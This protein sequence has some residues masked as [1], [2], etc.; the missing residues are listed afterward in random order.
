MNMN[1]K[2]ITLLSVIAFFACLL[3]VNSYHK[4]NIVN[5]I[6]D[7]RKEL[8]PKFDSTSKQIAAENRFF[9]SIQH[10]IS[11]GQLDGADNVINQLL[12]KDDRNDYFWN[13]KG[14]VFDARKQYDSALFYYDFAVRLYPSPNSLCNRALTFIKLKKYNEAITDYKNAYEQNSDYSYQLAQAFQLNK[15]KDSAL[16][17]YKIYLEHYPKDSN[18]VYS[19]IRL[20]QHKD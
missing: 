11:S 8:A 1:K 12:A 3:L 13:L 16:K 18:L 19:K 2:T 5:Q 20:L 9:D 6:D 15:Q 14:Q 17:Y 7:L 4:S 10:L